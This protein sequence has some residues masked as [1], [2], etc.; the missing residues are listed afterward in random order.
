MAAKP[1]DTI[2][3]PSEKVGQSERRGK[4]VEVLGEEEHRGSRSAGKTLTR[5]CSFPVPTSASRAVRDLGRDRRN[6]R[7]HSNDGSGLVW[8]WET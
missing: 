6:D 3:A 4:I 1:G 8:S 2:K 5:P 7:T